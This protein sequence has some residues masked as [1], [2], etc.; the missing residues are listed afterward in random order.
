MTK[1][2]AVILAAGK[3]TRMKSELPKVL[4]KI[5]GIAMVEHVIRAVK[6]CQ[7]DSIV[8]IIGN[9]SELV[10]EVLKDQTQFALQD[11]QLGTGHAV[12]QAEK[13]LAACEGHT[14]VVCG[15]TP[16][17]TSASLEKLFEHHR[18]TGAKATLLTAIAEDPTGYGRVIRQAG[19][20]VQAVVEQKDANQEE[21]AIQEVNTGTYIFDNQ[22]LFQALHKVDNNNAQGEFYLTDVVGILNQAGHKISAYSLDNIEEAIGV[23][24][25]LA[26]AKAQKLMTRRINERHLI[27]GVTMT[28]IDNTY[29][30]VD[31][32]I[33]SDC[34]IEPGVMLKGHTEIGQ[35]VTIAS[36]SEIIDSM[37]G[38]GSYIRQSVIES[39]ELAEGVTVGPFARIR[40]KSQL[41]PKVHI[42]NFVEVKNS[43]L[44][45]G[46]KAGHLAYIGDADLGSDVNVGCGVI[47]CNYDGKAKHRSRVGDQV[48]LGSNS[49]IVSPVA[50]D[51]KAFIAAGSTIVKDVEAEAL[52]I[53]RSEQV[54]KL[55]YW[56]KFI[57]K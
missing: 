26:L 36:H 2:M 57:N 13:L 50:I 5:S 18:E 15:D 32:K 17:L 45:Q 56:Q 39:A 52:A 46:T 1:R 28:D 24:D 25:R 54:N 53:S 9:G 22:A 47:F 19:G 21:L 37:I 20:D 43:T 48:F 31:V 27:N 16:L 14:I 49:N 38:D 42:G 44:A 34:L 55:N 7:V 4:H 30:E 8:T 40:P 6:E 29:I 23:N 33:G 41:G 11:Q 35:G 51:H 3:G 12:Q 10:Q